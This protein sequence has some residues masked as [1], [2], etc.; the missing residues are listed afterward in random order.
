MAVALHNTI[1]SQTCGVGVLGIFRANEE[2]TDIQ[3]IVNIKPIGGCG[4][5]IAGFTSERPTYA[6]AYKQLCK[7]WKKVYESEKRNNTRTGNTFFFCIFD[8]TKNGE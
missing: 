1:V 5:V 6:I 3:R 2:G 4:W 7:R 8:T